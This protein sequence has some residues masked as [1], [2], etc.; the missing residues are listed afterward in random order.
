MEEAAATKHKTAE[1]VRT[2]SE[3]SFA[4]AIPD[5]R[6]SHGRSCPYESNTVTRRWTPV[7][8]PAPMTMSQGPLQV[9]ADARPELWD[10]LTLMCGCD[11]RRE[12]RSNLEICDLHGRVR[13]GS[14]T[15]HC[16]WRVRFV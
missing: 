6:I 8:I 16:E 9:C 13:I 11:F 1:K 3:R 10:D 4:I 2:R 15:C 7:A 5:R 12:M 14:S